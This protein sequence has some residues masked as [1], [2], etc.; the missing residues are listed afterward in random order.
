MLRVAILTSLALSCPLLARLGVEPVL[1][2]GEHAGVLLGRITLQEVRTPPPLAPPLPEE[3]PTPLGGAELEAAFATETPGHSAGKK[4]KS[5]A[6]AKLAAP[7]KGLR[8]STERV[9][10]LARAGAVPSSQFVAAGPT[11][12]AGLR[13]LG[14]SALGIGMQDGDVLTH[15]A[16]VPVTDRGQVVNLVLHARARRAAQISARFSRDGETWLLVVDLP[17]PEPKAAPA[18]TTP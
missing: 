7:K 10:R 9:L 18:E 17:Y 2:R 14:V 16:G 15:V 5:A 4:A 3:L 6:R 12:A 11:R 1:E 8:V 13:L